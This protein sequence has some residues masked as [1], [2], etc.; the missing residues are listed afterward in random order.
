MVYGE[1]LVVKEGKFFCVRV[2]GD[3]VYITCFSILLVKVSY[4]V[5]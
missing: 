3:F 4:L 1:F 2:L 5:E